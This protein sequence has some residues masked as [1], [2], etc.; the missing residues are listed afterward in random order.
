MNEN[1]SYPKKSLYEI[2]RT[3]KRLLDFEK[4]DIDLNNPAYEVEDFE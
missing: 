1:K 4:L 3:D 2:Y